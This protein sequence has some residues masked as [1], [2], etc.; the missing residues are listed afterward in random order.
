MND[1]NQMNIYIKGQLIDLQGADVDDDGEASE[2]ETLHLNRDLMTA[3]SPNAQSEYAEVMQQLNSDQVNVEQMTN[4]HF[5]SRLRQREAAIITVIA[6][7]AST[8]LY[9]EEH[10]RFIRLFMRL[11]VSLDGAGR[12][13]SIQA[14][15]GSQ[16]LGLQ[17]EQGFFKKLG[18]L[19]KKQQQPMQ[20][21]DN[22]LNK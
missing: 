5:L 18:G 21:V 20:G 12:R 8:G 10:N 13:E 22:G 14:A 6:T 19:F 11:V 16:A 2:T 7:G 9:G 15:S 3:P 4:I 17:K 1:P